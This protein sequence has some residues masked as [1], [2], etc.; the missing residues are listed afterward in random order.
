MGL[1]S[2]V[3]LLLSS[4]KTR[5]LREMGNDF[6]S[7]LTFVVVVVVVYVGRFV[8]ILQGILTIGGRISARK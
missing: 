1:L 7:Q 3:L 2:F 4:F 6:V 8:G 5:R